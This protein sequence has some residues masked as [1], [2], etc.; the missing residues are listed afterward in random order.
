M[1]ERNGRS[2]K[3]TMINNHWSW[4]FDVWCWVFLQHVECNVYP[5]SHHWYKRRDF[6]IVNIHPT[7]NGCF[8]CLQ[9]GCIGFF[10]KNRPQDF[11][12][13]C[14]SKFLWRQRHLFGCAGFHP[15]LKLEHNFVILSNGVVNPL[16]PNWNI[17]YKVAVAL[18]IVSLA[19]LT[20]WSH[21]T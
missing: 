10:T 14:W 3:V 20:W 13:F 4:C 2:W 16:H 9:S 6:N 1:I 17:E 5:F 8:F 15:P 19:Y 11:F 12:Q 18:L 21:E 7:E